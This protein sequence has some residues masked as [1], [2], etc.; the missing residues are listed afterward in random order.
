MIIG[1]ILHDLALIPWQQ[2]FEPRDTS[3]PIQTQSFPSQFLPWSHHFFQGSP[4]SAGCHLLDTTT[5]QPKATHPFHIQI[6]YIST[7]Y[8]IRDMPLI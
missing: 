2:V 1:L 8:N 4:S 6:N 7:I 5:Q 3:H